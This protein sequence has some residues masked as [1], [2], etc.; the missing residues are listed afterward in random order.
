MN[1]LAEKLDV[2]EDKCAAHGPFASRQLF[3]KIWSK[4][5]RCSEEAASREAEESKRREREKDTE[6]WQSHLKNAGIPP[7]FQ[8]RNLDEFIADT[9]KKQAALS[10]AKTYAEQF[11]SVVECG[12]SAVFIGKPGTGKTHLACG[13]GMAIMREGYPVLFASV[14]RAV[15]RI[16][17][18]WGRDAAETESEAIKALVSPALLILDEVGIQFG[19][20]TEKMML[21]D[22]LNERYERQLPTI[23]ISNLTLSEVKAYLGERIFDRL[24]EDSGE[25]VTFD[26]ESHRGKA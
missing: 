7:R 10:F 16:K 9:P 13:I 8:A 19:S 3:G 12:R 6:R 22:V 17:E 1:D 11:A 25:V 20:E 2:R 14:L 18:T 23:L 5:P 26:W 21:F 15:R 4:C 24:R